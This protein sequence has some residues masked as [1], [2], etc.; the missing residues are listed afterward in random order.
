MYMYIYM[1]T[2]TCTWYIYMYK[3]SY[4]N[5][6]CIHAHKWLCTYMYMYKINVSYLQFEHALYRSAIPGTDVEMH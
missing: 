6:A 5:Y 2:H 3:T 4:I 1:Y